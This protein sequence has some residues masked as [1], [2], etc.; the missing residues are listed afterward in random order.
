MKIQCKI[1]RKGIFLLRI[2]FLAL[3]IFSAS[4]LVTHILS[5]TKACMFKWSGQ[6]HFCATWREKG[7]WLSSPHSLFWVPLDQQQIGV[8]G[9]LLGMCILGLA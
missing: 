7:H 8:G 9:R 3:H 2:I 4:N 6:D 5:S 1:I